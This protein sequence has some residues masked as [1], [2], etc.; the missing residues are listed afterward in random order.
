[1]QRGTLAV[2]R[3]G[4]WCEV[5]E[6]LRSARMSC[7]VVG[8]LAACEPDARLS[9]GVQPM[10]ASLNTAVARYRIAAGVRSWTVTLPEPGS[11]GGSARLRSGAMDTPRSGTAR[12]SFA[13]VLPDGRELSVGYATVALRSDWVWNFDLFVRTEDPMRTCFGCAGSKAFPLPPDFREAGRD[14]VWLVWG[15]NRIRDPVVY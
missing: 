1:M 7:V 12:V 9:V 14:S 11:G 6:A 13:L 3:G 10:P 2:D 8:T 4:R 5:R 15:G